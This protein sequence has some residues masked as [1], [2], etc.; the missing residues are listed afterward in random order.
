MHYF[1][2]NLSFCTSSEE[3][4]GKIQKEHTL[5]KTPILWTEKTMMVC[6]QTPQFCIL[7][8]SP[9]SLSVSRQLCERTGRTSSDAPLCSHWPVHSCGEHVCCVLWNPVQWD[10]WTYV[11]TKCAAHYILNEWC[12]RQ[13]LPTALEMKSSRWTRRLTSCWW[14][15]GPKVKDTW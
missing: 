5:Y 9:T 3:T 12:W 1:S 7:S 14:S 6:L 2:S 10:K 8:T 13:T 11:T 15:H 4:E